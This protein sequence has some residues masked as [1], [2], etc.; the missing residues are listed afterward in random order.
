MKKALITGITGQDGSYLSEL[1]IEKGYQVYGIV[2]RSSLENNLSR[3]PKEV[4]DQCIFLNG[5]LTDGSSLTQIIGEVRPDEIYNL[6]AQSHVKVSF[7]SP[8]YTGDC[9]GLGV[10]RIVDAIKTHNL[11]ESTKFYQAGTSEMFGRVQEVP[12]RETTPFYPRS[13]YGVAKLYAYWITRNYRE[14]YNLF[15]CTGILFNHESPRRGASFVTKKI[16]R[17]L[18]NIAQGNDNILELG[19]LNAKRD[20]GHAKDYVKAMWLMLQQ[21][22][23]DDYVISSGSQ[24][25]VRKFVE[26]CAPYFNMD[27]RWEGEGLYEQGIDAITN[28]VVVRV[29]PE[30]FRPAEVETLL[31]DSSKAKRV[32]GWEPEISLEKLVED[33]CVNETGVNY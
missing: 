29:N 1:L 23:A 6:A 14:S 3:I 5:D 11:F 4:R 25:S 2:R 17:T 24:V 22:Y 7:D 19:N 8:L 9:G 32:L 31:G 26:L 33:M 13:P 15:G 21:K 10:A 30:F 20:W 28:R 27:I 18:Y 16:T 12:Q